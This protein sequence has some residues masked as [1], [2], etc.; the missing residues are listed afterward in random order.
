MHASPKI[1]ECWLIDYG[2]R[3]VGDG[4]IPSA[5]TGDKKNSLQVFVLLMAAGKSPLQMRG[6]GKEEWGLWLTS[7]VKLRSFL[8][9]WY[10]FRLI[11]QV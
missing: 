6:P 8:P 11:T 2:M 10:Y 9:S 7:E 3:E 4:G 1:S 5:I